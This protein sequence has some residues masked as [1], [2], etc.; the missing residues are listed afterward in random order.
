MRVAVVGAGVAGLSVAWNLARARIETHVFDAGAA[1]AGATWASA[2]MLTPW[3]YDRPAALQRACLEAMLL[4]PEFCERLEEASGIAI[5]YAAQ[6]AIRIATSDG[7]AE[8]LMARVRRLQGLGARITALDPPPPY[9]TPQVKRAVRFEGEG[10]VDNRALGPA[11]T[12]AVRAAGGRVHE[13]E[14]VARILIAGGK[15]LGVE[16]PDRRM[17]CDV[18]IV[19]AGAW[20]SG[21]EGLP[22]EANPPVVPRKGQMIAF[23]CGG[24]AAFAGPLCAAGGFYAVPRATGHV[25]AGATVEDAGYSAQTDRDAI[26]AM[27]AWV[28]AC[29]AGAHAWPL[30]QAWAGLRPGTR[31]DVPI[32]GPGP[33]AGLHYATGQFRDGILLAPWIAHQ[34]SLGV[35]TGETPESLAPFLVSRFAGKEG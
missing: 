28:I 35:L 13:G 18:A 2:G 4:W 12:K 8:A 6:G 33:V 22:P 10:A 26:R 20:S 30:V 32:L 14:R 7:E 3:Q 23:E 34:V 1:G 5:G 9:L 19:A 27:R 15:V 21:I 25:V 16:T 11:L 24:P 29:V 31:D 17:P